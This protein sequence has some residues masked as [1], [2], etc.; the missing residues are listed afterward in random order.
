MFRLVTITLAL[1]LSAAFAGEARTKRPAPIV[2]KSEMC[3]SAGAYSDSVVNARDVGVP[4]SFAMGNLDARQADHSQ[5]KELIAFMRWIIITVYK[6]NAFDAT[7]L[8][9]MVEVECF[10]RL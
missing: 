2:T 9:Q 5:E 4:P 7:R 10:E 1:V 3:A 6:Y 8:R